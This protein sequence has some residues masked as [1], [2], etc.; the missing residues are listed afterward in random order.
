MT[1]IEERYAL[2][3]NKEIPDRLKVFFS[4]SNEENEPIDNYILSR[5]EI[6]K[7]FYEYRKQKEQMESDKKSEKKLIEKLEK[8]LIE[9]TKKEIE[10]IFK[11]K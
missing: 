4:S 8:E 2:Q 5:M 6:R 7:K 3:K 9:K 10:N 11:K 1:I